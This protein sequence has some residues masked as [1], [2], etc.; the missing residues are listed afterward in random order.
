[1]IAG[2][3]I[4]RQQ[5][6]WIR[7]KNGNADDH[8]DGAD[9]QRHDLK[10][11]VIHKKL[12]GEVRKPAVDSRTTPPPCWESLSKSFL[13]GFFAYASFHLDI[14]FWAELLL[15]AFYLPSI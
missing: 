14:T 15:L 11:S 6:F 12:G 9:N 3:P 1:M 10:N 4:P 8:K 2:A 13:E 7:P 5:L